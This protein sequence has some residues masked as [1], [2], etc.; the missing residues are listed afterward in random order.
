MLCHEY[1]CICV[2]I[3][4]TAGK[5][6]IAVFTKLLGHY[7]TRRAPLVIEPK[8]WPP[9]QKRHPHLS[10]TEFVTCGCCSK[11]VFASYF[12]FSMVRNPWD[13]IVSEYKYRGNPRKTEFETY[14]FNHLPKP[15]WS[16][17]YRHIIPQYEFLYDT[18]SNLAVDFVGRFEKLQEDFD[19]VCCRIGIPQ[20][21]LPHRNSSSSLLGVL[22]NLKDWKRPLQDLVSLKRRK[23]IFDHYTEYYDDESREFVENL[24]RKDIEAFGYAFGGWQL[25]VRRL[26]NCRKHRRKHLGQISHQ[27]SIA[28]YSK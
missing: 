1:K 26:T 14:L 19:E 12:K 22:R 4:K 15:S 25:A 18:E 27:V 11:E 16:D 17:A 7:L 24:Y 20:T 3:P 5:S 23:N 6:I 8:I 28:A 10:A 9:G 2:H 13:R 21:I